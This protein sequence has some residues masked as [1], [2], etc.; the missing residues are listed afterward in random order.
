MT[1]YDGAGDPSWTRDG[2]ALAFYVKYSD[3]S[4]IAVFRAAPRKTFEFGSGASRSSQPSWSPDASSIA[5]REDW[6][7]WGLPNPEATIKIL[8]LAT[9]TYAEVTRPKRHRVDSDEIAEAFRAKRAHELVT[10]LLKLRGVIGQAIEKARQEKFIG[11]ALEAAVI[12]RCDTKTIGGI[13]H[14]ELEEFFI[15]SDLKIEAA[16][17]CSAVVTKTEYKKC[18]RCWRHRSHVGTST[19]HPDLCDRCESVVSMKGVAR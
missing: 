1:P 4:K 7:G 13:S 16:A 12:L 19:T 11:N 10:E 9:N 8:S 15:L 2:E 14:E 5:V 6:G 18:A 3:T 17:D